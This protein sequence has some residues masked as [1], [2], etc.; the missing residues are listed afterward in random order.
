MNSEST[1]GAKADRDPLA[2]HRQ[3]RSYAPKAVQ[4]ICAVPSALL[5]LLLMAM[6]SVWLL[7]FSIKLLS[8]SLPLGGDWRVPYLLVMSTITL[9][10]T[11]MVGR[12]T[13]LASL[14]RSRLWWHGCTLALGTVF[15]FFLGIVGD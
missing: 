9:F 12:T 13:W 8:G 6:V 11:I 2:V 10:A 15:L 5:W 3:C 7:G 1:H 4:L 14:G